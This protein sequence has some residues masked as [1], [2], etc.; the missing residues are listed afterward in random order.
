MI[1]G[2]KLQNFPQV[3]ENCIATIKSLEKDK[4]ISTSNSWNVEEAKVFWSQGEHETAMK[5]MK[6]INNSLKV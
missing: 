1:Y 5:K 3:S 6:Q 2:F 4:K